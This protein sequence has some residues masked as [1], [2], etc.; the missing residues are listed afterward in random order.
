[1]FQ[2]KEAVCFELHRAFLVSQVVKLNFKVDLFCKKSEFL[3][4]S[5][6]SYFSSKKIYVSSKI[7]WYDAE[8]STQQ[9]MRNQNQVNFD[10]VWFLIGVSYRKIL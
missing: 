2:P 7:L 5:T 3:E 8:V 6:I 9:Y 1:M 4:G 10:V